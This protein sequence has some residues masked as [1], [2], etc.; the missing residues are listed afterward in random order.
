MEYYNKETNFRSQNSFS[1]WAYMGIAFEGS[2]AT[3]VAYIDRAGYKPDNTLEQDFEKALWFIEKAIQNKP[4]NLRHQTITSLHA[5][6]Y[7]VSQFSVEAARKEMHN[8]IEL[9]GGDFQNEKNS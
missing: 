1:S 8:F 2:V 6:E 5:L 7:L 9:M 3:F 4:R